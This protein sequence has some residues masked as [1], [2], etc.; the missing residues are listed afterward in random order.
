MNVLIVED[1]E[2]T[3]N[4]L[5]RSFRASGFVVDTSRDGLIGSQKLAT[6]EYDLIVLDISLPGK[7]GREICIEARAIGKTTPIIMLSV[8]GEV[9]TKVDLLNIGAD[10]YVTKPFSFEELSAR[11]RAL[12]RRP[13]GLCGDIFCICD[14]TLDTATRLVMCGAKEI[15]LTPREFALLEYLLRNQGVA[16]SRQTLLEHVW[17]MN[18]DPFTN[19]VETHIGTLR[20]KLGAGRKVIHTVPNVGYKIA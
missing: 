6:N 1:D 7:D 13:Q 5:A 14:I 17:D 8:Q 9:G 16:F 3:L 15:H 20:R 11:G 2:E 10:D 18:A 4:A 12:L 19:T